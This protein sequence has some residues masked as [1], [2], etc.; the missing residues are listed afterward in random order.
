MSPK[1]EELITLQMAQGT[2][3]FLGGNQEL[4]TNFEGYLGIPVY[5]NKRS[6]RNFQSSVSRGLWKPWVCNGLSV[7][8]RGGEGALLRR[9]E[10]LMKVA[11][12]VDFEIFQIFIW[13][14]REVGSGVEKGVLIRRNRTSKNIDPGGLEQCLENNEQSIWEAEL[15]YQW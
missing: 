15:K 4:T 12:D 7:M 9:R 5:K 13:D 3:L 6:K 8:E 1:E 10:V 11:L 2:C 14:V